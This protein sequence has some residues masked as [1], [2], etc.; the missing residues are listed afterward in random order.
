MSWFGYRLLKPCAI[1]CKSALCIQKLGIFQEAA[2]FL[3]SDDFPLGL[4]LWNRFSPVIFT[5]FF[6]RFTSLKIDDA[7]LF[8]ACSQLGKVWQSKCPKIYLSATE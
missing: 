3:Y 7:S 4:Y 8:I 2:N 5:Y 6:A 1:K